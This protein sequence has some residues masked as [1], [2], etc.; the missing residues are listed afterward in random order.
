[1]AIFQPKGRKAVK[2]RMLHRVRG[3]TGNTEGHHY[4]FYLVAKVIP[5][6]VV[7]VLDSF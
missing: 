4:G 5:I 1:M 2:P 6:A 7:L 3:S